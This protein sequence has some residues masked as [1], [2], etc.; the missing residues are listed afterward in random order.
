MIDLT[1]EGMPFPL[2]LNDEENQIQIDEEVKGSLNF[3]THAFKGRDDLSMMDVY[4]KAKLTDREVWELCKIKTEFNRSNLSFEK[5]YPTVTAL[6]ESVMIY[7]R[8]YMQ[9]LVK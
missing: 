7:Y 2:I 9:R 1:V 5:M 6:Q 4:T 8:E 3:K